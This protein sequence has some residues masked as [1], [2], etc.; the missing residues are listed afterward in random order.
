M[1][2]TDSP[3]PTAWLVPPEGLLASKHP[4]KV[5]P[6][7]VAISAALAF[8]V[9]SVIC[10]L[11]M[12]TNKAIF[13]EDRIVAPEKPSIHPAAPEQRNPTA[14][15]IHIPRV[16]YPGTTYNKLVAKQ[17]GFGLGSKPNHLL[18]VKDNLGRAPVSPDSRVDLELRQRA[19]LSS[20]Q[21]EYDSDAETLNDFERNSAY[22]PL[23][24]SAV[25]DAVQDIEPAEPR[26]SGR[27]RL[28]DNDS[29]RRSPFGLAGKRGLGDAY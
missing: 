27:S 6:G 19:Q 8:I 9:V 15:N 17:D 20:P 28:Y 14:D 12:Q 5:A 29:M 16:I 21:L 2:S 26:R 23:A 7:P 11:F 3:L 18:G 24:R 22:W 4:V 13:L 10:I 25:S 1:S